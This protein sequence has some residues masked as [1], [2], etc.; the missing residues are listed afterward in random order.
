MT[1]TE[2]DPLDPFRIHAIDTGLKVENSSIVDQSL[3]GS[4]VF[5]DGLKKSFDL[6]FPRHIGLIGQGI[7]PILFQFTNQFLRGSLIA[8]KI[9]AD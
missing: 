3:G 2:K 1:F 6:L 7:G 5:L 9:D 8:M 4:Q